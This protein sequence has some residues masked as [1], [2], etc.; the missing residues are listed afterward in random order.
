MH[1]ILDYCNGGDLFEH[2]RKSGRLKES[3]VARILLQLLTAVQHMHSRGLI[4]R[5]LK[6][7]N[8]L[9]HCCPARPGQYQVKLGDFG[10]CA[11]DG[12]KGQQARGLA[13][14]PFYMAPEVVAGAVYGKQVDVWSMGVVL[15]TALSGYLPFWG[16][17]KEAVFEAVLKGKPDM[18]R[19]PWPC[20]SPEAKQLIQ[21]ML[22]P[23]V[24]KRATV[25]EVLVHPWMLR[26]CPPVKRPLMS[27]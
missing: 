26:H 1:L 9:L 7:E 2:I 8:I 20:I 27:C 15:Y 25:Q 17:S 19:R 23:A 10:L 6:P 24:E 11:Q 3:E 4:H 18:K 12:T 14:S 22:N 21:S 5:D 13:G 16:K